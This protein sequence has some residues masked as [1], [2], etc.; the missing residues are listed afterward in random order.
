MG[1]FKRVQ[2]LEEG[3]RRVRRQ[4]SGGRKEPNR[5]PTEATR[6]PRGAQEEPRRRPRRGQEEPKRNPREGLW[7]PEAENTGPRARP[8]KT[9]VKNESRS[10][11]GKP[12]RSQEEAKRTCAKPTFSGMGCRCVNC[13]DFGALGEGWEKFKMVQRLEGGLGRVRRQLSGGRE[14]PKRSPRRVQEDPRGPKRSPRGK[15]EHKKT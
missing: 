7:S 11:S 13:H 9:L 2:K 6:R 12:K 3:R 5:S 4:L 14:E 15:R 10:V 8:T 1:R